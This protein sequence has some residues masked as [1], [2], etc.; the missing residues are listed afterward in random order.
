M[1]EGWGD[2]NS[3]FMAIRPGD[4][5]PGRAYPMA[6]YAAAGFGSRSAYFGIR[7]APYSV[8]YTINPFTFTHIRG[9]ATLPKTA[10][11][12][13]GEDD[14]MNEAHVVGEI[15][16]QTMFEVYA[17]IIQVGEAA[18]R[19]FEE[20]QR[21]MA[22]YLVAALKAAPDDPTFVEQRDAFYSVARAMAMKDPTRRDD[23]DAMAR[24][25]AKRGLGAGAVAPPKRSTSL[26][27]A[28]ESFVVQTE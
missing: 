13:A 17:N 22:D 12:Q 5:F 11:I 15:W 23:V 3:L 1:S 18:G 6:Q 14:P 25:F 4:K 19:P 8:E 27:E 24:G 20:S 21:R 10:P 26:N 16:A 28:V 7:R 9:D 2:F